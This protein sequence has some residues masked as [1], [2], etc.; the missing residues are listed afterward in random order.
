LS[1]PKTSENDRRD[2]PDAAS[3]RKAAKHA[4]LEEYRKATTG[5]S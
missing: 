5:K 1:H 4:A 3:E 2:N